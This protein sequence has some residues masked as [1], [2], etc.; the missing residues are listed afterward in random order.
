MLLFW[1]PG[2]LLLFLPL[3]C[4]QWKVHFPE[5][6]CSSFQ[7]LQNIHTE[8]SPSALASL[9]QS[10]VCSHKRLRTDRW[11]LTEVFRCFW[12]LKKTKLWIVDL[13]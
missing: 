1:G 12:Y 7:C 2:G 5:T 13:K 4:Q 9:A 10:R 3:F 6:L 8:T 11:L